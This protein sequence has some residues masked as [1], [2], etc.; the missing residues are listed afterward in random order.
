MSISVGGYTF[1]TRT[2]VVREQYEVVGGKQTR[3]IRIT[4]LL[5]GAANE[6]A[7][8][9]A[10]DGITEAAS[11]A[12]QV[13]VS[14]RPGRR[15]FARREGFAREV[16]GQ[17]LTGQFVLDLRA[18]T[19]WEESELLKS[20]AWPIAFSGA[21][22]NVTNEGN[23]PTSPV[24][25]ITAEDLLIAPG[26]SDGIRSLVYEGTVENGSTLVID[27][28]TREVRLDGADV[29]GYTAGEFP[30]LGPGETTLTY[31]DD[32]GSSHLA[33]GLVTFR[34]RWW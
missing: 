15:M 22:L 11:A 6:A 24:I 29:T 9:T 4:G 32:P 20:S 17:T 10:L 33:T 7:L 21:A 19:A 34:D 26:F 18:E 5:R 16:N 3:A 8:I 13:A 27:G 1:N 28:E 30:Q 31:T 14:L 12:S 25:T 23:L 2:T